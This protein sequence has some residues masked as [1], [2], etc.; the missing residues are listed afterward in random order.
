MALTDN[1]IKALQ[2]KEKSYKVYHKDG[3][4]IL[5]TKTSKYFRYDCKFNEKRKTIAFGVYPET[6]LKEA[7][8]KLSEAKL[9]LQ[10]KINP[11]NHKNCARYNSPHLFC[12]SY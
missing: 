1:A 11:Q 7:R 2:L 10:N 8:T 9:K 3:L 12:I 4:Y 6:S 5:V